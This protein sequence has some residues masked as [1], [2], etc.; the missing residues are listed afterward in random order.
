MRRFAGWPVGSRKAQEEKG[1]FR[2]ILQILLIECYIDTG[3]YLLSSI[4]S[5]EITR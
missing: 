5:R 1:L 4:P 2:M 3:L